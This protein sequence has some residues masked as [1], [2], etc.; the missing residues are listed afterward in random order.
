MTRVFWCR[1]RQRQLLNLAIF[2]KLY[3]IEDYVS[4]AT[5]H[6]PFDELVSLKSAWQRAKEPE[7]AQVP[8]D[9]E[10]GVLARAFFGRRFQ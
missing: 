7:T 8:E 4:D 6:P 10:S 1:D 5:Y 3:V 9:L 2:E